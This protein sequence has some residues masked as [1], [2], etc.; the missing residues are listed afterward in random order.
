M[1]SPSS[2]TLCLP[3]TP[4]V[5]G[6]VGVVAAGVLAGALHLHLQHQPRQLP[7]QVAG[8][9]HPGMTVSI[10]IQFHPEAPL[11][12]AGRAPTESDG[13]LRAH[14]LLRKAAASTG[15]VAAEFARGVRDT[16]ALGTR[17]P[18]VSRPNMA[19]LSSRG[20]SSGVPWWGRLPLSFTT[21]AAT[22]NRSALA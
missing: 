7:K 2:P 8:R 22:R 15:T 19:R 21:R 10:R 3:R 9:G 18:H 20:Q 12:G 13:R 16:T 17:R 14:R 5:V 6:V 4:R 1:L 11:R